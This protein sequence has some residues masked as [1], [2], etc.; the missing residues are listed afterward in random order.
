MKT[1]GY[2]NIRKHKEIKNGD[3]DK[4]EVTYSVSKNY[5]GRSVKGLTTSMD[6]RNRRI[7]NKKHKTRGAN[8]EVSPQYFM[9]RIE[10]LKV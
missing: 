4:R 5:V 6:L 8:T 7:S 9:K 3:Q 2:H 1:G 10:D